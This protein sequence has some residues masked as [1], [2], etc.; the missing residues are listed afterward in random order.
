MLHPQSTSQTYS[1]CCLQPVITQD[2]KNYNPNEFQT[3]IVIG[4]LKLTSQFSEYES[5]AQ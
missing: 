3:L 5:S 2:N 4:I 1:R